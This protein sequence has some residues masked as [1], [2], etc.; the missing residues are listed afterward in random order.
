MITTNQLKQLQIEKTKHFI[1]NNKYIFFLHW[2]PLTTSEIK[3]F[4]QKFNFNKKEINTISVLKIKNTI[5]S[6][7]NEFSDLNLPK[8][9]GPNLFLGCSSE[10]SLKQVYNLLK[11]TPNI[12]VIGAFIDNMNLNHLELEVYFNKIHNQNVFLTCT[13]TLNSLLSTHT[14]FN[15]FNTYQSL[16]YVLKN[17]HSK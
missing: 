12:I 10:Q 1:Q 7:T 13:T 15:F 17:I 9:E 4:K 8:I 3:Q 14:N 5:F 11:K 6:N 16:N 2:T